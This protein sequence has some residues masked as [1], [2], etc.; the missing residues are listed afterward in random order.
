[1]IINFS[2]ISCFRPQLN[3]SSAFLWSRR[4]QSFL[5]QMHNGKNDKNFFLFC[6]ILQTQIICF[7]AH[8]LWERREHIKTRNLCLEHQVNDQIGAVTSDGICCC[9]FQL[10]REQKS[11]QH[12]THSSIAFFFV[13]S[14]PRIQMITERQT[15]VTLRIP[16]KQ[17]VDDVTCHESLSMFCGKEFCF[18]ALKSI[19]VDNLWIYYWEN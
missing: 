3:D 15:F 19:E 5:F 4:R 7:I 1:M 9:H 16:I 17:P 8:C 12:V 6:L 14:S 11:Q 2:M 10:S 13:F 18:S